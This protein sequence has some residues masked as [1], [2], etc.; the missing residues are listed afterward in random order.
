MESGVVNAEISSMKN[1]ELCCEEEAVEFGL[2][3]PLGW[4]MELWPI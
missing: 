2:M 4:G 1:G 3:V